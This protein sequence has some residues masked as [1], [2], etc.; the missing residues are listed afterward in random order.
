MVAP[1]RLGGGRDEGRVERA[2]E[3][4]GGVLGGAER[5]PHDL[6]VAAQGAIR[7]QRRARPVDVGE[8]LQ[9]AA[10]RL[11]GGGARRRDGGRVGEQLVDLAGHADREA[12]PAGE[13][14]AHRLGA[15]R[16]WRGRLD[17]HLRRVDE[18]PRRRV[19]LEV[20]ELQGHLHPALA[21]GDRVVHLLHQRRPAATEALD[22]DELPQRP[23]AVEGVVGEQGRQVEQLAHRAGLGQGDAADVV[24][25]V[26]V[27]VVDPRRR[28]EVDGRRLDPPAQAGHGPGRLL[29]PGP[30]GVEVRRAVEHRHRRERRGQVGVL[31]D[32]PHQPLGVGHPA[33]IAHRRMIPQRSVGPSPGPARTARRVSGGWTCA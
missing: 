15:G 28:R 3:A 13:E 26:E 23:G 31:V 9:D 5:R 22:D 21:V 20:E 29:H 25:D 30:Q 8:L 7:P 4:L 27:G 11:D 14:V 2:A 1:R 32:P 12:E 6:H 10:D 18:R 33:V 24:V 19:A 16:R 17:V